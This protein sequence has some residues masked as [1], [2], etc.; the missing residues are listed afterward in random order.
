MC[1]S[2]ETLAAEEE[3]AQGLL[4]AKERTRQGSQELQQLEAELRSVAED[5]AR[6]QASL[7]YPCPGQRPPWRALH[8]AGVW[9]ALA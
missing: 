8:G 3:V 9:R 2:A 1:P 5:D 6:L 7:L 4:Q